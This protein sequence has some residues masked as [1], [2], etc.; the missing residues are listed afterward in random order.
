MKII[1]SRKG[2]DSGSGGAPSPVFPD[3]SALS[4]PIPIRSRRPPT[5][6]RDVRWNG[7]RLGPLVQQLTRGRVRGGDGCHLDPDIDAA[8]L[9]RQVGWRPAFGQAGAAQG[10][11]S[12]QSVGA[13]DLF[14]FFGW[15]RL[16]ENPGSGW[17]YVRDAPPVHRLFGW[18]QIGEV[19]A[20]GADPT[21]ARAARPWLAAHPHLNG[22]SW[23]SNNTIY[24]ATETLTI[25]GSRRGA[26]GAAG[27]GRFHGDS[28]T[29]SLT[30]PGAARRSQWRLPGWLLLDG[31]PP[32]LSYHGDARR[33]RRDGQWVFLDT[34]PRGQEFVFDTTGLPE[35]LDWLRTLFQNGTGR[36]HRTPD[37]PRDATG[38]SERQ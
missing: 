25:G 31:G 13:G 15:F 37:D 8:A 24:I 29:L 32:R 17:R 27:A 1:F 23:P 2:F 3:G 36:N 6:Y 38:C 35:A 4:L 11:L 26:A 33:W 28:A 21:A 14:L 9:P 12:R 30:A 22:Q 10:H 19:V 5:R 34:V 20:V 16:A 7:G 18:L